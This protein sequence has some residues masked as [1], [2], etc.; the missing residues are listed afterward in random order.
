[1]D[2]QRA[3]R[4]VRTHAN[5][6]QLDPQ[7]IGIMGFSAGGHLA[8]SLLTHNDTGLYSSVTVDQ[9]SCRPDFGVLI[10]PVISTDSLIYHKGSVNK[11]LGDAPKKYQLDYFA[12]ELQVSPQTPP[13]FIIHADDDKS[14]VPENSIRFYQALR[15][16]KVPAALHIYQSGGHG[17]ALSNEG[18]EAYLWTSVFI[19]WLKSSGYMTN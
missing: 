16:N 15:K 12:N 9:V 8:A 18:K 1:M 6:W 11:L 14:V 3:L 17:F 2:V 5:K 13:T 10:Y 4:I 7:H 19:E